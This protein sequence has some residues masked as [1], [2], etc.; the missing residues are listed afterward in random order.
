M[1]DIFL[2]PNLVYLFLVGGFSLAFMAIL[3]PGT[4]FLEIAAL[5]ALAVAGWGVYHLPLNYWALVLLVV[6]VLPFIFVVRKTRKMIYLAVSVVSLVVGSA[7]L[8]RG[9]TWYSL[10]VYPALAISVSI[11]VGGLYWIITRK[12]L[13]AETVPPAHDLNQ[14][15]GS[16][17]EAKSEIHHE[18]SVQVSKEVWTARSETTI[19]AGAQVRV[20]GREGFVLIVEEVQS[21]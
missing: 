4:G 7:F 8:V 19:Q 13:E 15:V 10:A 2:N 20:V 5:F 12:A 17:G 21:V 18:G 1:E 16:L 14:L 11:L 6:G 9:E 3:T